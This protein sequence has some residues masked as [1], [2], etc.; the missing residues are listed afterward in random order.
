MLNLQFLNSQQQLLYLV[1]F[2]LS[3]MILYVDPQGKYKV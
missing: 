2:S 3:F 1:R